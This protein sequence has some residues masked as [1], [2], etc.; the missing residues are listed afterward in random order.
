[1]GISKED[2]V[3]SLRI[4]FSPYENYDLNAIINAFVKTVDRFEKII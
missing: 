1:M 4:S 3:G 2:V